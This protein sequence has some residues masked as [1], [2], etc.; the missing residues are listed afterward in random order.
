MRHRLPI[1]HR[2][3]EAPLAQRSDRLFIQRWLQRSGHRDLGGNSLFIDRGGEPHLALDTRFPR[4]S[5]ESG[6]Q[7]CGNRY[8][9]IPSF[10][11]HGLAPFSAA[12]T[13]LM[14][15]TPSVDSQSSSAA[16]PLVA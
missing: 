2:R 1:L 5:G 6:F 4:G 7:D 16:R 9:V 3:L 15:L 10:F 13:A 11:V 14:F 8:N 12:F